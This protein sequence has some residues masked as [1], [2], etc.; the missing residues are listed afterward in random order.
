[1]KE[2]IQVSSL[3]FYSE[4]YGHPISDLKKIYPC[5]RESSSSLI[6]TAGDS[7]LDNK[8]W[9]SNH[10]PAV[11][12]YKDLLDPPRSKCDVTYW[13]NFIL[14]HRKTEDKP[15]VAA[16]NTAVEA[17]TL[18]SR[19]FNLKRHDVFLRDNISKD[20]ILIVSVGG[21]DVALLPSPC[22]IFSALFLLSLPT[23]C[24]EHGCSAGSV[25]VDDY[26]WGCGPSLCSCAGSCPPC[27][28]YFS[29]LFGMRVQKYI[30]QL[31]AKTKPKKILVCMIYYLDETPVPS[32]A[33][34]SL[35]AMGYDKNPERL[36][37]LTKKMFE[38]ATW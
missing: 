3:A 35:K 30:E 16:I 19:S 13:L 34:L 37:I 7:S 22:T 1:M 10:S 8:Y 15:G 27:L 2:K 24:V 31:T 25:P 23:K 21:N 29:H 5:L 14:E 28:G 17:T 4:Y 18:N 33:G 11:G 9:F 6:W 32:W 26:C 12:V 20:D 38:V 36:Q